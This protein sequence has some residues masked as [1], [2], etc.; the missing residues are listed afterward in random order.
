MH[1]F[2]FINDSVML[3]MVEIENIILQYEFYENL[4]WSVFML[5][6]TKMIICFKQESIICFIVPLYKTG[7]AS[8]KIVFLHAKIKPRCLIFERQGTLK[9]IIFVFV[10]PFLLLYF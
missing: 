8:F 7:S 10:F 4:N 9:G 1:N 2:F 3:K 6:R 5:K